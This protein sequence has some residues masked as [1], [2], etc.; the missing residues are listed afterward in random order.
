M[1]MLRALTD[2]P[3]A[4]AQLSRALAADAGGVA[5]TREMRIAEPDRNTLPLQPAINSR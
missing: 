4:A 1:P 2:A 5:T 3:T